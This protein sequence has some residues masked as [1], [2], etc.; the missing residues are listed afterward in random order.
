MVG[1]ILELRVAQAQRGHG[2]M[3]HGVTQRG[4]LWQQVQRIVVGG[5]ALG[6]KEVGI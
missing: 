5:D 2:A 6:F 1:Q 4:G 3:Q